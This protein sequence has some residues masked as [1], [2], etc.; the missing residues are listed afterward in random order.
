MSSGKTDDENVRFWPLADPK[1]LISSRLGKP[2]S[3]PVAQ[4]PL[5]EEFSPHYEGPQH[6]QSL[7]LHDADSR[8]EMTGGWCDYR[9]FR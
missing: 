3:L 4:S 6:K 8:T 2:V 5:P 1:P 9:V 7:K